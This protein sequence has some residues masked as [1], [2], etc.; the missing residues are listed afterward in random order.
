MATLANGG[1]AEY[2]KQPWSYIVKLD[3]V[4]MSKQQEYAN[5]Y[6]VKAYN[7]GFYKFGPMEQCADGEWVR[8]VEVEPF[9]RAAE[10]RVQTAMETEGR[11]LEDVAYLQKSR[12]DWR[13]ICDQ[14]S[15]ALYQAS[16]SLTAAKW[17]VLFAVLVT[18]CSLV[19][20]I[21]VTAHA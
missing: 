2:K 19:G 1:T 5:E 21:T 4:K 20:I 10:L 13:S 18:A 15:N 16:K 7:Q 17:V 3:E 11:A 6:G 14:Q 12:D 9:L 8:W